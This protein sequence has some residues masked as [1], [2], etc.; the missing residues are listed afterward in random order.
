MPRGYPPTSPASPSFWSRNIEVPGAIRDQNARWSEMPSTLA[1]FWSRSAVDI[2]SVRDQ[3]SQAESRRRAT[4][5]GAHVRVT[6]SI[7][8]ATRAGLRVICVHVK[9]ITMNPAAARS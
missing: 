1:A 9:R 6:A 4:R 3:N 2:A 5:S 8:F 7:R